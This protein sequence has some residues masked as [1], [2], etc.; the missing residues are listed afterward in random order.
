MKFPRVSGQI[1]VSEFSLY[2][3]CQYLLLGIF[4]FLSLYAHKV[5]EVS[6]LT[7][8]CAPFVHSNPAKLNGILA[9]H[10]NPYLHVW[11][12]FGSDT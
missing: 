2:L 8:F 12:L 9:F 4:I 1:L 5:P 7:M 6:A 11:P 10:H 3:S